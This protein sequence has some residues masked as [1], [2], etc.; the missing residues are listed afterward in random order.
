[1]RAGISLADGGAAAGAKGA[2]PAQ[3]KKTKIKAATTTMSTTRSLWMK[4]LPL[5]SP[6]GLGPGLSSCVGG[7]RGERPLV[8]HGNS[9]TSWARITNLL[10]EEEVERP[11]DNRRRHGAG[12]LRHAQALP[13]E[14]H[15][16]AANLRETKDPTERG[17]VYTRAWYK[18]E[19]SAHTHESD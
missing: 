13:V 9:L 19:R 8:T 16:D 4:P 2:R 15:L 10:S 5:A 6:D 18:K 7:W 12:H 3:D 11:L 1:M 14:R 17:T